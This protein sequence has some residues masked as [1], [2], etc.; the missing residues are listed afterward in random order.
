MDVQA[1][2]AHPAHYD[3]RRRVV[4]QEE[5]VGVEVH[6]DRHALLSGADQRR[7]ERPVQI[8]VVV[9]HAEDVEEVFGQEVR[10]DRRVNEDPNVELEPV[11]FVPAPGGRRVEHRGDDPG[12]REDGERDEEVAQIA[13]PVPDACP[14][15]DAEGDHPDG[16]VGEEEPLAPGLVRIGGKPARARPVRDRDAGHSVGRHAH[17]TSRPSSLANAPPAAAARPAG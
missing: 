4:G 2:R 1:R 13:E 10:P 11:G 15:V 6:D 7:V 5:V 14:L 17:I 16:R 3:D 12:R 8:R 9:D